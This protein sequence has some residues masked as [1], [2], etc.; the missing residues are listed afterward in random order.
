MFVV[1][2]FRF[3]NR[4]FAVEACGD[5]DVREFGVESDVAFDIASEPCWAI[6]AE[7]FR[8]E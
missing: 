3:G 5:C 2:E 8:G 4:G 7:P 6:G 1:F